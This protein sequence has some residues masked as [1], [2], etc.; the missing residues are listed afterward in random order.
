MSCI[1]HACH[2]CG[3]QWFDNKPRGVC[4]Q[5]GSTKVAHS[6]DEREEYDADEEEYAA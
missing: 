6:F 4:P 2:D 3:K 5:C 1:T